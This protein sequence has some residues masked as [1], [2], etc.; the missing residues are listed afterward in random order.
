MNKQM[1]QMLLQRFLNLHN[2]LFQKAKLVKRQKLLLIML[3]QL[4]INLLKFNKVKKTRDWK[5]WN[6]NL[7]KFL[8][9]SGH[10]RNRPRNR[11]HLNGNDRWYQKKSVE[12]SKKELT[13]KPDNQL[14]K[15]NR[16]R[17]RL[18]LNPSVFHRLPDHLQLSKNHLLN[19]IKNKKLTLK[20][21]RV[22]LKLKPFNQKHK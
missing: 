5:N 11:L 9:S 4:Q 18:L 8:K 12:L 13:K 16:K 14:Y 1:E 3:S 22:K 20:L 10:W 6:K 21:N 7:R 15:M 19:K 17:T 2:Q